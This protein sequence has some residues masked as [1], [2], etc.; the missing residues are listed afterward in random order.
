M[1]L[2]SASEDFAI[3]TLSYVDGTLRRLFYLVTLRDKD[4]TYRHWG[5]A[6]VY[7][8]EV[9]MQAAQNAHM[10][11]VHEVLRKPLRELWSELSGKEEAQS[12]IRELKLAGKK[13]FPPGCSEVAKSHLNLVLHALSELVQAQARASNRPAA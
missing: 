10:E 8:E 3:R 13:L 2:F 11:I 7:G 6:Q 1:K 12:Q 4:G 9:L 5:M